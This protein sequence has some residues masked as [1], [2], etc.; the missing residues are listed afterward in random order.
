M[1]GLTNADKE[2]FYSASKNLELQTDMK[3]RKVINQ[4]ETVKSQIDTIGLPASELEM[5]EGFYTLEIYE[6]TPVF[7]CLEDSCPDQKRFS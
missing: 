2:M 7:R 1:Q 3:K 6:T 4:I 5:L